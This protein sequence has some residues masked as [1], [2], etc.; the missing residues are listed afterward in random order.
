[1]VMVMVGINGQE[2]KLKDL[3]EEELMEFREGMLKLCHVVVYLL[4]TRELRKKGN[5]LAPEQVCM[6]LLGKVSLK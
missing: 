5:K 4:E 1:M 3:R 2:M 6:E